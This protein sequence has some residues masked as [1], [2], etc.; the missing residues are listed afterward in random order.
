VLSCAE[1]AQC[2]G[3]FP[4]PAISRRRPFAPPALPGFIAT[5]NGSEFPAPYALFLAFQACRKLRACARQ[6]RDLHGYRT[7][8][9][10]ARL[11]L[12]S[13]VGSACLPKRTPHCCLLAVLKPS[14][15]SNT[16]ISGLEPSLRSICRYST[17]LAFVPTPQMRC[18]QRPCK[19]RYR[20]CG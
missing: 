8:V 18:R 13:R 2:R 17:S 6:N 3:M 12:R 1:S 19:A 4:W 10:Q 5:M 20:A 14:A 7:L 9:T 16:V 15:R 11:G